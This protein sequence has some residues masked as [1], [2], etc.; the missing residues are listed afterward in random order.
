MKN[1]III[2]LILVFYCSSPL[3]KEKFIFK[4]VKKTANKVGSTV[5]KNV[6]KISKMGT[7]QIDEIAE[8]ALNNVL[9]K[10]NKVSETFVDVFK[11]FILVHI[12]IFILIL[13]PGAKLLYKIIYK[14]WG[15][16]SNEV[17]ILNIFPILFFMTLV[18]PLIIPVMTITLALGIFLP[19]A[20]VYP[21]PLIWTIIIF[22]YAKIKITEIYT[23][24]NKVDWEKEINNLLNF[25]LNGD[26]IKDLTSKLSLLLNDLFK[27]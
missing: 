16:A 10:M 20:I 13:G 4:K 1:Y 25:I 21:I 22:I 3:H 15:F 24:L 8:K 5:G 26:V 7:K 12:R 19:P 6:V 14:L 27:L 9:K 18:L 2:L 17:P 11:K 23:S